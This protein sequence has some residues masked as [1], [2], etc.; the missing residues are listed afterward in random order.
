MR[1]GLGKVGI[2]FVVLITCSGCEVIKTLWG[3][4]TRALEKARIDGINQTFNCSFEECFEAVLSLGRNEDIAEPV[5]GEKAY[6]VFIKDWLK[7]HI[8]VMGVK[9]NIETTEVGIFFSRRGS[10]STNI[11]ISSLSSSAKRKVSE[12]VFKELELRFS[13]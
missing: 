4:S 10:D 3:S 11:E 2:V 6:D 8:I 9:G 1:S 5:S 12:A 13:Q 7:S